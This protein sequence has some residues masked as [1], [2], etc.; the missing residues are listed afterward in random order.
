MKIEIGGGNLIE[1]LIG[2]M[3]IGLKLANVISWPWVWVLSPFWVPI[4]MMTLVIL[5]FWFIVKI[6]ELFEKN[7][8]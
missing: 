3:F 2:V 7:P 6:M 5:S 1:G 4:T 8:R